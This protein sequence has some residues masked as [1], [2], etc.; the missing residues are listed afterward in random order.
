MFVSTCLMFSAI[1]LYCD[2]VM[3]IN[4]Y[5]YYY[6]LSFTRPPTDC[7]ISLKY[8]TVQFTSR[9][10]VPSTSMSYRQ[11][12]GM[13]FVYSHVYVFSIVCFVRRRFLDVISHHVYRMQKHAVCSHIGMGGIIQC[14]YSVRF[15][16]LSRSCSAV[17]K[18]KFN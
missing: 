14:T 17:L 5:Y 8:G 18:T 13:N 10:C 11:F 3:Q 16:W 2:I 7:S 6:H 4:Y 12:T 9:Y 1:L 15:V